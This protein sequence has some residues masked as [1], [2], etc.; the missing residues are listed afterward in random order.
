MST[1]PGKCAFA[2]VFLAF[3]PPTHGAEAQN[4]YD[5]KKSE[6][7]QLT[8]V[9]GY[10]IF[11]GPPNYED[12]QKG[13]TPEPSYV[14]TLPAAICLQGDENADPQK[15]FN[16]VQLVGGEVKDDQLAGLRGKLV[17]VGLKDP[18]SAHTGHHHLPLVA[19]VTNVTPATDPTSEYGTPATTV[20]AFYMALEA[21]DGKTAAGF[22]VPE[23]R[24]G[25]PL[26]ANDL[27]AFYGKLIEPLKLVAIT[28][29]G[30]D[31]YLVSYSFK[32]MEHVCDGRAVVTTTKRKGTDFIKSIKALNGC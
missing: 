17:T 19:S 26:S 2:L 18:M 32:S 3:A 13:D 16:E 23:K 1:L 30:T 4:C 7:L 25:G 10:R 6:P 15:S 21:G 20:R 27:T 11:P 8:G 29:A 22:V 9:L 31:Q 5:L 28:P 24:N 12:V 14:L